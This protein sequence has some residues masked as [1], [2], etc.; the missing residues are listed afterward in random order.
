[1]KLKARE[2]KEEGAE[3]GQGTRDEDGIEN[4]GRDETRT[5]TRITRTQGLAHSVQDLRGGREGRNKVV[6]NHRRPGKPALVRPHVATI[7]TIE[8]VRG[9]GRLGNRSKEGNE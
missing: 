7:A 2:R 5:L 4:A 6:R 1:M 3:Q 8:V 9:C